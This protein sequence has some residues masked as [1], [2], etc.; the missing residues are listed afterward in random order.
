MPQYFSEVGRGF[1]SGSPSDD[2]SCHSWARTPLAPSPTH[3]A[4]HHGLNLQWSPTSI[5][6]SMQNLNQQVTRKAIAGIPP[7]LN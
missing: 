5:S 3:S 2:F 1:W 4:R 7:L 6:G